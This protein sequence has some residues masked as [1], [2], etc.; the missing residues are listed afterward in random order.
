[1]VVGVLDGD[2]IRVRL[3]GGEGIYSVRYVGVE[4]P[5]TGQYYAA[6]SAGRNAEL[7]YLKQA[8]LVRDL[9][10]SDPQG[11]LLRYVI[12][13]GKFVNYELIAGGYAQAISA[14]PDTACRD[15]FESAQREAQFSK[16]GLWSAPSYLIPFSPT[17]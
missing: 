9:T 16:L 2:T 3:D 11:T 12:A 1:L 7:V 6:I 14:A 17:P 13:E 10:D 5:P 15:S 4:A 8:T